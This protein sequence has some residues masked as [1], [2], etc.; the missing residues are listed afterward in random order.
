MREV[1]ELRA[2]IRRTGDEWR[3]ALEWALGLEPD[4]E[5]HTPGWAREL[6]RQIREIGNQPRGLT[7]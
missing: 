1:D 5:N 6:V 3:E 4:P 7:G 2:E